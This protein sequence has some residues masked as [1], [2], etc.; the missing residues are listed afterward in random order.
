MLI[1][2]WQQCNVVL[3]RLRGHLAR[4]SRYRVLCLSEVLSPPMYLGARG[5][6]VKEKVFCSLLWSP[7]NTA[8][9]AAL[10]TSELASPMRYPPQDWPV[11][12]LCCY[13]V[14]LAGEYS[15]LRPSGA[16]SNV[17]ACT[18]QDCWDVGLETDLLSVPR[19][20]VNL[21]RAYMHRCRTMF[22]LQWP[23][24]RG[25]RLTRAVLETMPSYLPLIASLIR[26]EEWSVNDE[27]FGH[28]IR[29]LVKHQAWPSIREVCGKP[30]FWIHLD[31]H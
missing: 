14:V 30:L 4:V 24:R 5:L 8:S 16:I 28:D 21:V 1:Q 22:S 7:K 19:L 23:S 29:C 10:V 18:L 26:Y 2:R 15:H 20:P 17:K 11:I 31:S 12:G 3:V 9:D 6:T 27:R 25:F 13:I